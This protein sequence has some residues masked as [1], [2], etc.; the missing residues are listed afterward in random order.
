ML[1]CLLAV[2]LAQLICALFLLPPLMPV[3][4]VLW[5]VLC[6]LPALSLSLM[7]N[8]NEARTVSMATHKNQSHVNSQVIIFAAYII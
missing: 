4:H 7:G 2:V 8:P 3:Q 1:C 6:V 5:L